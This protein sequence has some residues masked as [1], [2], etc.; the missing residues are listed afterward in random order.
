MTSDGGKTKARSAAL[1]GL[2]GAEHRVRTGDLRL[3]NEA[4]RHSRLFRSVQESP[5]SCDFARVSGARSGPRFHES[6]RGFSSLMCPACATPP[7]IEPQGLA[8]CDAGF[9]VAWLLDCSRLRPLRARRVA[10]LPGPAER[11]QVRLPNAGQRAGPGPWAL[12]ESSLSRGDAG[13][14]FGKRQ[15]PQPSSPLFRKRKCPRGFRTPGALAENHLQRASNWVVCG[16]SLPSYDHAAAE[17]LSRAA[18]RLERLFVLDPW[19]TR[20]L[21]STQSPFVRRSKRTIRTKL[22]RAR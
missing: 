9:R 12:R 15:D 7:I 3:G 4:A 11:D 18:T 8:R 16:Y 1:P 6:P 13:S 14:S 17:V 2:I 22:G 10:A 5:R 21:P 19:L 20:S